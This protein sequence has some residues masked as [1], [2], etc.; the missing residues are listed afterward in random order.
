METVLILPPDVIGRN[1]ISKQY[2]PKGK[3]EYYLRNSQLSKPSGYWRNLHSDEIEALVKNAN[4]CDDWDQILVTTPFDPSRI[5]NTEFFGLVRIGRLENVIV[6]HHDL[7]MPAGISDSRIISC[8]IGDDVAI[9]NVRYLAHYIIGDRCIL[10]NIDEMHA[11]NHAKFGNG[12]LKT[13]ESEDIRIWLDL[14]NETGGRRILPFD[15]MI[16]ADAFIWAR[17]REDKRLM[18]KLKEIT[19]RSFDA[20]RGFYGTIGEQNVIKSCRTIKDIKIGSHCYIKGANKLKNLTINS[21][22]REP[23]Q[24]GEGVELVNGIIGYGCHIFY[25]CKAVR[26]IMGPN[27]SL[28]YGARLIHSFMGDNSLVSCCEILY[29]LIF[30]AHEQ[31]HNNSFLTASLMMG[32]SNLPAGATI[33][34]NHN[35]RANDGEVHAGRGF[36]PGL[37]TTI[38]H[39]CTFASF[40]L[41]VKGD[42]PSEMHIPLPFSLVSNDVSNDRLVVMPAFWWRHNMYALARNAWKFPTRDKRITKVQHI[43]YDY[44]APDTVEEIFKAREL[45]EL[46]TGKAY[47]ASL[48][49]TKVK[50]GKAALIKLGHSILTQNS[51]KTG[52]LE[53]LGENMEQS[54]RKIVIAKACQGYQAYTDMLIYYGVK[55]II[56][57]IEAHTGGS[58]A[59]LARTLAGKRLTEWVNCGGQLIPEGD[60][61]QLCTAIKSGR[62]TSW[63]SIHAAYD[64]LWDAYPLAK[65]RHAYATICT[66]LG[67]EKLTRPMWKE[68]LD[69]FLIIQEY[70]RDQVYSSR[71]KDYRNPIRAMTFRNKREARAVTGDAESNSFVKQIRTETEA[72]KKKVAALRCAV[73]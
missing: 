41:L 3:D 63:N 10:L 64:R 60:V 52:P 37:C 28:K 67:C 31:H 13:G 14:I 68:C 39:S 59:V 57:F 12:I 54:T 56:A 34:S 40:T 42:Y 49:K 8:D 18:R 70:I 58:L 6:Q 29:N 45:L 21:N 38:K 7:Q 9:H 65:Q 11:T 48:S 36:W 27:C 19:Q 33:G 2:L 32:Q 5:K 46:W 71:D 73:K 25:G 35:S 55:N 51:P 15:G 17:Y 22:A 26:F 43:E 1:F 61:S 72:I 23:T 47:A 16:P 66:V 24:I 30:P 20:R 53:I 50:P 4:S 44:L 69:R 62:M